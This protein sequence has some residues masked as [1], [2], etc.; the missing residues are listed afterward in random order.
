MPNLK[1]YTVIAVYREAEYGQDNQRYATTVQAE[2]P[3]QAENIAQ[4]ECALDNKMDER[5]P[6][7]IAGVIEGEV[8][9]VA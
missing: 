5:E 4:V 3:D 2:N 9:V 8:E 1:P 7:I 6:L